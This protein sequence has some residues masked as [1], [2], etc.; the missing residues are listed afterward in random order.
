[1]SLYDELKQ[2]YPVKKSAKDQAQEI[3]KELAKANQLVKPTSNELANRTAKAG[4]LANAEACDREAKEWD[5]KASE[6]M[7]AVKR[8]SDRTLINHYTESAREMRAH[9]EL[10]RSRAESS[11]RAAAAL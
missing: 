1:M 2:K 8:V 5:R 10:S 11:R 9:A 3:A 7:E 4:L 6:K